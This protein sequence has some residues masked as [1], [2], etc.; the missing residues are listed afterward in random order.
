MTDIRRIS[1]V[2]IAYWTWV[3]S[4]RAHHKDVSFYQQKDVIELLVTTVLDVAGD[5]DVTML[6][7]VEATRRCE[8]RFERIKFEMSVANMVEGEISRRYDNDPVFKR[9]YDEMMGGAA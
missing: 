1:Q 4:R 2:C 8:Q 3:E 9:K 5:R 7:F 6:H